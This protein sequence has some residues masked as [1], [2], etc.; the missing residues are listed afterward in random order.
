MHSWQIITERALS[1]M[2][3][4]YSSCACLLRSCKTHCWILQGQQVHLILFKAGLASSLFFG[5]CL[6]QMYA[7]CGDLRDAH[8]SFHEMPHRNDFSWNSLLEAHLKAGDVKGSLELFDSMP[9]KNVFSWNVVISEFAKRGDLDIAWRLFNDMP[10]RNSTAW[11]SMIHGYVR[12]GRPQE[13]LSLFKCLNLE[14]VES[15]KIDNFVLATVIGAS[16]NLEAI[17]CG[18]QIHARIIVGEVKLDSVLVSS[19]VNMYGKCKE[20]DSANSVL[21]MM[22]EPDDFSLSAMISGYANCGRLINAQ[23]VVLSRN[24][25]SIALWNSMIA[26]YVANNEGEQAME[27]FKMMRLSG[28]HADSST[29]ASV[30]S[31][32]A[33]LCALQNGKQ[34][35]AYAWK[36]GLVSDMIVA[37]TLVDMYSKC[38][39][40]DD[41]CSFF[42]ELKE[43]DT[44]LLNSMINVYSNC[45]RIEDARQIFDTM[46]QRS[47]ISWNSMIVGYS[48]NGRAIEALELFCEMH[49]LG[50]RMDKTS[51]ASV[52]STCACICSLRLGE[53]IFAQ[54]TVLGLESDQI[55]ATSLINL[56]CKCGEIQDGRRLFD[57]M[58]KFNEIP[59]NSMLMGYAANGYGEEALNLFEDMRNAGVKP[60]DITFVGVLSS[61]GHCGLVELGQ[62]W[63]Y[64]MKKDYNIDPMIE[65]YSCMIDLFA[66]AGCIE[67][68]VDF[69]NKMPLRADISMWSS[70]LRGCKAVGNQS[71]GRLAAEQLVKLDPENSGAYVQLSSI[72]AARGEWE[73]SALVRDM[74]QEMR[75]QKKPGCSWVD[76]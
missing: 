60:N 52:I 46:P 51:L 43:C 50:L 53:Q 24:N 9:Y 7:R 75:I 20:L 54:A 23:R 25:P 3:L 17:D 59:W 45:G 48:H 47:L 40:S 69:I 19:L 71:V 4:D 36:I 41:A 31:A 22:K 64:A 29:F 73:R 28:I 11:N 58:R 27:F 65:H 32:C 49:M 70:V 30:L 66:R 57:E 14:P 26:G 12:H 5:N 68:A 44:I 2:V 37:S 21:D 74:M 67:E 56:Y 34:M 6:L 16:A 35:H 33:C 18:K 38:G 15:L 1:V 61:C 13:A 8:H 10:D 42:S 72:Y 62:G 39:N 76:D 63:F 55:I